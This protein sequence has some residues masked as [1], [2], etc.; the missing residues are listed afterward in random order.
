MQRTYFI[1]ASLA[2]VLAI[3][4]ASAQTMADATKRGVLRIGYSETS[5]PFAFKGKDGQPVGYSVELCKRIAS[6]VSSAGGPSKVEWVA[7]TPSTRLDAVAKGN[8]DLEC[9]TTTVTMKRR[10]KVDFSLPIFVDSATILA[11]KTSATQLSELQGKKVAVA[12]GTTT[13]AALEA[14]L[15]KR[16]VK[17]EIVK[18]KT[19]SEGFDLLK[20][21]KVD[22]L[23]SDRTA[24]VGTFLQSGGAEGLI[25]FGED[26]SYEPYALVL[27]KGDSDFRLLVD[28][29]LASLY[30]SGQI[31]E[32]YGAWLAPLGK[33]GVPLIGMYLLNAYPE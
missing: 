10:E 11:R 27:R 13:D 8:V 31:E 1:A 28:R 4:A 14:G 20:D 6:A 23:A 12:S 7:L 9:G 18:T 17:A 21:G 15:A 19:V 26:L 24:L 32:I 33:P 22:A 25:V 3:T 5:A 16:F 2:A 30:R 29:V